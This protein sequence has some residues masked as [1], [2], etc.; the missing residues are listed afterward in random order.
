MPAL[1]PVPN[2]LRC[3][4][5]FAVGADLT[6]LVRWHLRYSGGPP[7]S[8]DLNSI[9]G[10]I[11][12][13]YNTNIKPLVGAQ[14]TLEQVTLVD[15]ASST[16]AQGSSVVSIVGTLVGTPLSGGTAVL[17]N[18]LINRR[19]RGGKPRAYWPG[20]T[21]SSLSTASKW[22]TSFVNSW[23]SGLAS[24]LTSVL[25]LTSG[26]TTLTALVNVSYYQGFTN[27]TNPITGRVRAVPKLR[28]GGPVVDVVTLQ[29]TNF[30]P[31]TQRR[32][33]RP[34]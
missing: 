2:T 14:V 13:F 21:S 24:F 10:G 25:G 7:S 9:A 31:G 17:V 27:V 26:S 11:T 32:R 8:S 5:Q 3:D 30:I 28:A 29:Q 34:R 23:N 18:H 33:L 4:F 19:Y 15:I 12:G 22:T 1:P 16:G 6:A 20:G